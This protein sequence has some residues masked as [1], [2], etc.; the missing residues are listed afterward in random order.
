MKHYT[1]FVSEEL[2]ET[3]EEFRNKSIVIL[4]FNTYIL[5]DFNIHLKEHK[6]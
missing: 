3:S 1:R 2:K 5:F 6:K 4:T